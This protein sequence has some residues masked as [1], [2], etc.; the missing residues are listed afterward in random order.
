MIQ[1]NPEDFKGP[2]PQDLR[3]LRYHMT[4]GHVVQEIVD[5]TLADTSDLDILE[6][7]AKVMSTELYIK[8]KEVTSD[9]A[10]LLAV[11]SIEF[12]QVGHAELVADLRE[13]MGAA[14]LSEDEAV[15]R[16]RDFFKRFVSQEHGTDMSPEEDDDA[17][18]A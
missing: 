18:G 14:M 8:I 9:S 13:A 11:G 16:A 10:V 3:V 4:S 15:Q 2:L 17:D 6:H 5:P 7:L 12:V 1:F